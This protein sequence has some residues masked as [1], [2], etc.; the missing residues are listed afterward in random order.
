MISLIGQLE[1]RLSRH[2]TCPRLVL[3]KKPH[4]NAG[5]MTFM[6]TGD[7]EILLRAKCAIFLYMTIYIQFF[8]CFTRYR[9]FP[10]LVVHKMSETRIA[11]GFF[12]KTSP[13]DKM[14]TA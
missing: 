9:D 4:N 14:V 1:Q 6:V 11:K 8:S 3:A 7:R 13:Y 12:N 2:G 5:F 10:V